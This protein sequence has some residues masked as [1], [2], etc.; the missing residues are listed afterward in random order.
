MSYLLNILKS[1]RRVRLQPKD[2]QIDVSVTPLA[3]LFELAY[4]SSR[5]ES[6]SIGPEIMHDHTC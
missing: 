3:T 5:K 4:L 2:F 6:K 1:T